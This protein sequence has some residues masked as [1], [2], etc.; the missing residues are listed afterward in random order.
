MTSMTQGSTSI[1]FLCVHWQV[2]TKVLFTLCCCICA[3]WDAPKLAL[4]PIPPKD[5]WTKE[6]TADICVEEVCLLES[7][8]KYWESSLMESAAIGKS[9]F[10][11]DFDQLI[12]L[13][14]VLVTIATPSSAIF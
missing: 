5:A 3:A 1:A 10:S 12:G 7:K 9:S 8:V 6:L 13:S 4:T 14:R 2:T 11:W